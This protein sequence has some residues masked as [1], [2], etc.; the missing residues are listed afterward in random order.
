MPEGH[1]DPV[2]TPKVIAGS[3]VDTPAIATRAVTL[4][5]LSQAVRDMFVSATLLISKG[6]LLTRTTSALARLA[7]G[8]NDTV[9]TADSAQSTGVKWATVTGTTLVLATADQTVNNS[10]TKVDS[11]YL[12]VPVLTNQRW[13]VTGFLNY[14]TSAV[15]DIKIALNA[16][17]SSNLVFRYFGNDTGGAFITARGSG[18]DVDS[19]WNGTGSSAESLVFHLTLLAGGN[20]DLVVR[21]AQSTLEVSDTKLLAGCY[22]VAHRLA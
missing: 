16:P 15:A 12:K 14:S 18:L 2:P 8:A 11:T 20:G 6:D 10:T 5:T 17:A 9:L 13:A 1:F 21:F 4:R 3:A 22:L 19:T 7:V